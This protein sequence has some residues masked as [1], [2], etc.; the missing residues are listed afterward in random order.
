[1]HSA[2]EQN[3]KNDGNGPSQQHYPL[4][5]LHRLK[6]RLQSFESLLFHSTHP[7]P[8]KV[9]CE[10]AKGRLRIRPFLYSASLLAMKSLQPTI[11]DLYRL[12]LL[13][14]PVMSELLPGFMERS[15]RTLIDERAQRWVSCGWP[16]QLRR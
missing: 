2:S 3:Q 12:S 11:L 6:T 7:I 9:A 4:P 5:S 16:A 10:K 1:M 13:L 8:K 15:P 14:R